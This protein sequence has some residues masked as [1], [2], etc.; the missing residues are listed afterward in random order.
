MSPE[1]A[2]SATPRS[3]RSKRR[4]RS[5]AACASRSAR[6][7]LNG[8]APVFTR[9]FCTTE[10]LAARLGDANLGVI[11]ATWHLPPTGRNGAAEVR[12]GHIPGAVLFDI[13]TLA[14]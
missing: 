12:K 5:T 14:D 1:P 8:A 3:P 13:D 10:E 2:R 11:D 4:A 9:N 6:P 7:K